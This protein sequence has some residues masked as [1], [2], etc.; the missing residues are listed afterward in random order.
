MPA[1]AYLDHAASSPIRPEVA[2]QVAQDLSEG[3]GG[4]A[5]PS[6]QHASGRRMAGLLAQARA[7]IARALGVDAH[8]VVLTSGGTEASALMIAGRARAV[9]GGRLVVSPIEHPAV[10]DSARAAVEQLGAG[11]S[12]LEVDGAGRVGLDSL[13][14]SLSASSGAGPAGDPGGAGSR[15]RPTGAD[16]GPPRRGR[17]SLVS[18]MAANNET[19]VVQDMAAVVGR[20]RRATGV[21]RP[22]QPGYVPVHCDAVAALGKTVVDF[23]GWGLDAMSLSGHKL[24]A[25]VGVGALVVRRE[26]DL[27]PVTGGGGQERGVRSGTQDVIGA[28]ALALAVELAVGEREAEAVRLGALRDRLLREATALEGVHATLPADAAHLPSTAHLWF[29]GAQAE[30]LLMALDLAGIDASAGSA[31]HAGVHGPSHVLLAM[32]LGQDAARS[33][34]RVSLGPGSTERDVE[35]LVTALPGAVDAARRMRAAAGPGH[36]PAPQ[37][38]EM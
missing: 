16:T 20:V 18:V 9:P 25:P 35:R 2:E 27:R 6:S 7:R 12:L 13:T 29:E 32:G 33:T 38:R 10:L 37:R 26:V 17:V 31:C 21:E 5:N 34:L 3:L 23:R 4:W 11:L 8:E 15:A 36:S 30:A 1:R 14:A 28:R 19:G 24:G 22:G